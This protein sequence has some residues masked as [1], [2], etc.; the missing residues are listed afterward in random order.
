MSAQP[1]EFALDVAVSLGWVLGGEGVAP[2]RG[3][4]GRSPA[5][6]AGRG[7]YVQCR[8]SNCR[9]QQSR[10]AGVTMNADQRAGGDSAASTT[11]SSG[12]NSG[13]CTCRRRTATWWRRT[14]SSTSLATPSR[15]SWVNI[16]RICRMSRYTS[17]ALMSGSSPSPDRW[18]RTNPHVNAAGRVREPRKSTTAAAVAGWLRREPDH[19]PGG[20]RREDLPLRKDRAPATG[21]TR[22]SC[23][24][25]PVLKASPHVDDCPGPSRTERRRQRLSIDERRRRGRASRCVANGSR[26]DEC[27]GEAS[28]LFARSIEAS[29]PSVGAS[30]R[31]SPGV[32]D[33]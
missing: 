27:A 6:R 25:P 29:C 12:R 10:V 33:T 23:R 20:H 21:R 4:A 13:R 8:A 3:S 31:P 28:A 5:G 2:A 30:V 11:R 17:E 18:P 24:R 1:R 7:G 32:I 22:P 15:A 14:S 9:C 16:C 19:A 26:P